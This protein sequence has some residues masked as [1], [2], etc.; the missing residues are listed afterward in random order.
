MNIKLF[1]TPLLA[2]ALALS[3]AADAR[4]D[5]HQPYAGQQT[6]AVKALS[7]ADIEG[8]LAGK[9]MGFAKSAEL[10]SYPGPLHALAMVDKLGL[11]AAQVTKIS[12][13][14]QDMKAKT[15][16][17]GRQLVDAE[18]QLDRLFAD[19]QA[20][21]V[22]IEPLISKI[23]ALS[24]QIRFT[25]LNTHL[26]MRPVLADRQV[27][28]YDRL[29]GYGGGAHEKMMPAGEMDHGRGNSK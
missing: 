27:A 1:A 18:T 8:Y 16:S 12:A 14:R 9:G 5:S 29:R 23:G 24:A 21:A 22:N 11:S 6:R 17:L 25:H 26:D 15:S 28:L 20:K 13:L 19:G 10:N 3:A 4:A 7:A 2:T